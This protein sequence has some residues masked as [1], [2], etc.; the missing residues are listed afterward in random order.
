MTGMD[1][2]AA[3]TYLPYFLEVLLWGA[4]TTVI[5]TAGGFVVSVAL[6]IVFGGFSSSPSPL[7]RGIAYVYVEVFRAVPLLTLLFIIYFGLATIGL[8]FDA[9]S[10]AIIGFGVH[11]GAYLSEVF[12]AGILSI[13]KGQSE[14]A[15]TIGM[16]RLMAFRYII[17]PQSVRV[18][19]P[20]LANFAIGLL[21]D[22][23]LASA[24]AAPEMMFNAGRLASE[25]FFATEIYLLVALL[26]LCMSLP[27]SYLS[28]SLERRMGK[29]YAR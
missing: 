25:T 14:A 20:P 9:I 15:F 27:L 16:T 5:C 21:K 10:A 8:K 24:V 17:L 1:W 7:L 28:R 3:L 29:G 2:N 23:S 26:Y 12:R 11:G 18:V 19:L 13:N 6:G 22:T 4:V